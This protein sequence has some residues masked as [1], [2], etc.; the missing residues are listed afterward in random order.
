MGIPWVGC[1]VH[2]RQK[3]PAFLFSSHIFRTHKKAGK[4]NW[5]LT[6]KRVS[7]YWNRPWTGFSKAN[8]FFRR[9]QGRN[10]VYQTAGVSK[11][12]KLIDIG[13]RMDFGGYWKLF[14]DGILRKLDLSQVAYS[15]QSTWNKCRCVRE[16][17]Q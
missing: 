15:C 13:L 17:H 12:K 8:A 4:S 6:T 11:E 7:G 16:T 2:I 1:G 9:D 14:M 3:K 5:E 10:P